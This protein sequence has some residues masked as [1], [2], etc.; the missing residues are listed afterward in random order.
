MG[1]LMGGQNGHLPR[2]EIDIK[3]P[4]ISRNPEISNLMRIN[5][6]NSCYDSLF[7]GMT[8]ILHKRQ[9]HSYGVVQW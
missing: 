7:S 2:L 4:K 9:V 1:V 8:L 3:G 5:W 6:F